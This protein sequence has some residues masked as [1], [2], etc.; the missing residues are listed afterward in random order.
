M[1]YLIRL[2]IENCH[3]KYRTRK[4]TLFKIVRD[5]NGKSHLLC[6]LYFE[7]ISKNNQNKNY[8][9]AVLKKSTLSVDF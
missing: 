1:N 5:G 3:K 8:Y 7:M 2:W 4:T 6:A 9:S